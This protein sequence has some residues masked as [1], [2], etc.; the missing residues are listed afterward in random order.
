MID[1]QPIPEIHQ[2]WYN[3]HP[4]VEKA[5]ELQASPQ[6]CVSILIY[7]SQQ[8]ECIGTRPKPMPLYHSPVLPAK[9]SAQI[10]QLWT[11]GRFHQIT[12]LDYLVLQK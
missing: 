1:L 4:I 3:I 7:Y 12:M 5:H 8:L 6:Y 2:S 10:L 11:N 9:L